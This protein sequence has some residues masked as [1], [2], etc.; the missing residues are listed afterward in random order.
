MSNRQVIF[1]FL[2][3]KETKKT[4]K[5]KPAQPSPPL[6]PRY[7]LHPQIILNCFFE[8]LLAADEPANPLRGLFVLPAPIDDFSRSFSFALCHMIIQ[9]AYR[10]WTMSKPT[11]FCKQISKRANSLVLFSIKIQELAR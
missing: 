5:S 10:V 2:K 4:E 7:P 3:R 6:R 1:L 9:F 8:V 11:I